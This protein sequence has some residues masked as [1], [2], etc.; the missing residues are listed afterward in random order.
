SW[1]LRAGDIDLDYC[2]QWGIRVAGTNERHSAVGIFDYLGDMAKHLIEQSGVDP[3]Q[4]VVLLSNNDFGSYIERGLK[5]HGMAV[6]YNTFEK[7]SVIPR[8]IW[9]GIQDRIPRQKH[10]GMTDDSVSSVTVIL[11]MHPFDQCWVSEDGPIRSQDLLERYGK[12]YVLR[13]V[14][15]VDTT[16]LDIL[17][18]PYWPKYVPPGHMGVLP[19]DI[20]YAPVL[21]LQAAGLKVGELLLKG[22]KNFKEEPLVQNL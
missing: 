3:A 11:C 14:G 15:D 18:I 16:S 1:E 5:K 13:F 21:K 6:V 22:Q 19:S 10:R 4:P 7:K 9:R 2:R 12:P 17:N 8:S 20:G